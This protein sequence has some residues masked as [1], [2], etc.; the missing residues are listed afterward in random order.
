[1][2]IYSWQGINCLELWAKVLGAHSDKTEL[3]PLVYPLT[4]LMLGAARLVPTP[5]FFPLRLR[6]IRALNRCDL[7]GKQMS[8]L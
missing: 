6:L 1:M 4:Q 3:K 5:R 2:Q 7:R 8:I